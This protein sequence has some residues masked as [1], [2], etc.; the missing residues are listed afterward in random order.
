MSP[1]VPRDDPP[2]E[3]VGAAGLRPARGVT[4]H[5]RRV[6]APGTGSRRPRAGSPAA[7]TPGLRRAGSAHE[8]PASRR[9]TW[10]GPARGRIIAPLFR[11][12]ANLE[13]MAQFIY[14][15]NR[16]GK[17]VPPKRVILRDI[18]LSFFPGA[19]IGVLGLNG[20]GKSTLLRIMAGHGHGDRGRGAAAA[21]HQD[22]LPAAG[23]A[24]RPHQGRARQRRGGRRPHQ[25][26]A[27]AP[28]RG[29]RGL[30]RAGRRL[31]QDRRPSR[32][33]SRRSSRPPTATT[34]T[35]SSRSPPTR[36][37]CRPGT[38]TSRRSR[39]ASGAAW[40]CASCCCRSP[41]CCCSTSRPTTSTPSRCAGSSTS[42]SSTRAPSSP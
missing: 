15:M 34:S 6:R 9:A 42:S 32:R 38:P 35:A 1:G 29:L 3:G 41:T 30:R 11:P 21:G 12:A 8:R 26:R 2:L 23:A 33:S 28:R 19:K 25:G 31:R 10:R 4:R 22:R 5:G 39:A 14:T 24:A 27:Q 17:V 40:R 13:T 18:S 7:P 20:S 16:V 36:C 37:A